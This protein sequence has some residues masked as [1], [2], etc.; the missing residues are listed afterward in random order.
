LRN[1]PGIPIFVKISRM[2]TIQITQ[3]NAFPLDEVLAGIARLKTPDLEHFQQEVNLLLARR[4]G[5]SLQEQESVLLEKINNRVIPAVWQRY[6]VLHLKMQEETITSAEHSEL[7]TLVEQMETAN[8]EWLKNIVELARLRGVTPQEVMQQLG[9]NP[10][11][12]SKKNS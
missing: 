4:R 9:I 1:N 10:T 12:A 7:L 2:T 3:D 5:T 11:Y 8:V 6:E